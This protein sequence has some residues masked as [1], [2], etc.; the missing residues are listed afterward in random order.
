M[1][2]LTPQ[3]KADAFNRFMQERGISRALTPQEEGEA[4]NAAVQKTSGAPEN[5]RDPGSIYAAPT[6]LES[7]NEAQRRILSIPGATVEGAFKGLG[8]I[9]VS[10]GRGTFIPTVADIEEGSGKALQTGVETA[11]GL[12]SAVASP[13]RT[14]ESIITALGNPPM[15]QQM[16]AGMDPGKRIREGDWLG[17]AMDVAPHLRALRKSDMTDQKYQE[18][19]NELQDMT[20]EEFAAW[21]KRQE[22]IVPTPKFDNAVAQARAFLEA[23][24]TKV[25]SGA[26]ATG[27]SIL[28]VLANIGLGTKGGAREVYKGL[29]RAQE[30]PEGAAIVKRVQAGGGSL[31]NDLKIK[32]DDHMHQKVIDSND[33][34]DKG[35]EQIIEGTGGMEQVD[36]PRLVKQVRNELEDSFNVILKQTRKEDLPDKPILEMTGEELAAW[37]DARKPPDPS[38]YPDFSE[39][40]SLVRG[41][42]QIAEKI[43]EEMNRLERA[44]GTVK[45]VHLS[46][47]RIKSLS[48]S[49]DIG[50]ASFGDKILAKTVDQIGDVLGEASDPLKKLNNSH[51]EI[52]DNIAELQQA[53]SVTGTA[54]AENM[55]KKL[56]EPFE[57]KGITV[58]D[59]LRL[60]KQLD[61]ELGGTILPWVLGEM[62]R[63]LVGRGWGSKVLQ[64]GAVVGAVLGSYSNWPVTATGLAAIVFGA[65]GSP[66]AISL[67]SRLLGEKQYKEFV[68][69]L[70]DFRKSNIGEGLARARPYI[71]KVER[72]RQREET[73]SLEDLLGLSS[74]GVRQLA[75]DPQFMQELEEETRESSDAAAEQGSLPKS[76][77]SPEEINSILNR[78][79]GKNFV[80]RILDPGR[81]PFLKLPSGDVASHRM[82]WG[83]VDGKFVVFPTIVQEA[84]TLREMEPK[85]AL[86]H[87]LN[88]KEFIS[89]SDPKTADLFSRQ[90]KKVWKDKTVPWE[91]E[92]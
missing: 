71:G 81:F 63:P 40:Y 80:K 28:E 51:K 79:K 34:Y 48:E 88:T 45:D 25:Q 56:T 19:F 7:L 10:M 89:F 90:Y 41:D 21:A 17:M 23:A 6:I 65:G 64:T 20:D 44:G 14:V 32:I 38:K 12:A 69:K 92:R 1:E 85:V 72:A 36:V 53:F 39:F 5:G 57:A 62:T 61:E 2:P 54:S 11:F 33:V 24:K 60:V 76:D 82:A 26:Q 52:R 4:L 13:V 16:V 30:T 43:I 75:D 70:D 84:D 47:R 15:V 22:Q 50:K 77:L 27:L 9:G 55:F 78:H 91:L 87:A 18:Y 74:R 68:G 83:E 59:K 46:F 35:L 86:E 42:Q 31:R 67:A 49:P 8:D 66:R 29:K 58:N 3:E 73:L 37:I